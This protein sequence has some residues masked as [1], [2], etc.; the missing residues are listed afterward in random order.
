[1]VIMEPK[2]CPWSW[3]KFPGIRLRLIPGQQWSLRYS[4]PLANYWILT[5]IHWDTYAVD[6][7][8]ILRDNKIELTKIQGCCYEMQ[9]KLFTVIILKSNVNESNHFE[10]AINRSI[11][12]YF[13]DQTK[14]I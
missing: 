5:S 3:T 9:L 1:M 11:L 2:S 10:Q 8:F 4:R 13:F 14:N 7:I 12:I 6:S